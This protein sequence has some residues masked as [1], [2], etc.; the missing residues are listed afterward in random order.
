MLG[1]SVP[2]GRAQPQLSEPATKFPCDPNLFLKIA[3]DANNATHVTLICKH[4]EM[5]QGVVTGL[6]TLVA[7]ELDVAW[8]QM[9]FEFAP[10]A[11][12]PRLQK[13]E[14]LPPYSNLLFVAQATGGSTSTRE[15]WVQM[16]QVGATARA[17]FVTA[18]AREWNV[19]ETKINIKDGVITGGSYREPLGKFAEVAMKPPVPSDVKL[20]EPGQWRLIGASEPLERLDSA[21]KTDGSAKFA[22]DYPRQEDSPLKNVRTVVICRP[23][24]F[25]AT[26]ASLDTTENI[27]DSG[28]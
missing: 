25:G 21:A 19:P 1:A 2:I 11:L 20:K 7:E 23:V 13:Q 4:L 15:A 26:V 3:L 6:A 5:G 12:L 22:L 9:H 8:S 27:E 18:A 10:V 16:R 28:S 17:M 24:R 14:A